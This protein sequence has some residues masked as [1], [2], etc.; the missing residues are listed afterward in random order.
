MCGGWSKRVNRLIRRMGEGFVGILE[1]DCFPWNS[2]V[3]TFLPLALVGYWNKDMYAALADD[4][5]I[6]MYCCWNE[7]GGG[8]WLK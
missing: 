2:C 7:G 1:C 6:G 3:F 4:L 8:I 5:H